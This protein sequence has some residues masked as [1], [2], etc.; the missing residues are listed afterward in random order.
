MKKSLLILVGVLLSLSLVVGVAFA[1]NPNPGSEND[2][3]VTKSYVDK[4]LSQIKD[5]VD[6]LI[7]NGGSQGSGEAFK[8]VDLKS[9]DTITLK[10]GTEIILRAGKAM[11]NSPTSNGLSDVTG[12][13]DL[14]NGAQMPSNHL[15]IAPR[16]DGRSVKAGTTAVFMVRGQYTK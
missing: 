15:L 12:G 16:S 9:G 3:V 1:A 5:Y 10:Q 14:L 7:S 8:V 2:P 6:G 13:K 11:I 4:A